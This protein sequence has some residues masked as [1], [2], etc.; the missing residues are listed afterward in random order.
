MEVRRRRNK[1][2]RKWR[3]SEFNRTKQ[4]DRQRRR[5]INGRSSFTS[6]QTHE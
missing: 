6:Y 3:K 5:R 2:K 1:L 4:V